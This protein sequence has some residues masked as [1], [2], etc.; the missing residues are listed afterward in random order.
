MDNEKRY[1]PELG[2][3]AFGQ[4]WKQYAASELLIAALEAISTRLDLVMG[5]VQRKEYATPFGN[6]A[7]KFTCDK[8][9]VEA[10]SWN[11]E[12]EQPF[13]FKWRDIEVSW[14]KYLG[15]GTTVNRDIKNDE[16]AL[17]LDDCFEALRRYQ[18][19]QCP[20]P[21]EEEEEDEEP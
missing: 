7:N 6:T 17:M 1:E 8:F 3:M 11:E 20:D 13:N 10:Y 16:I 5:N 4:P 19:E 15:R 18:V 9:E 12:Y 14:Y 2:Q 21:F